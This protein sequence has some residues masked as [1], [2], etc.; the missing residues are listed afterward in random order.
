MAKVVY[1]EVE[2]VDKGSKRRSSPLVAPLLG[3]AGS[4]AEG[5]KEVK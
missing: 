2:M 3:A 1:M 5:E 4:Q